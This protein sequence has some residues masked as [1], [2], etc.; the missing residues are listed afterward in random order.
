MTYSIVE[1]AANQF[2]RCSRT[3]LR[4]ESGPCTAHFARLRAP[5]AGKYYRRRFQRP[6][7]AGVQTRSHRRP[8]ATV[9]PLAAG[10]AMR[11][12]GAFRYLIGD[13]V[14]RN[15]LKQDFRSPILR[16]L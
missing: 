11:S 8:A 7:L 9:A 5:P 6:A 4:M 10:A 14:A 1:E 12:C 3:S 16:R 13:V 15:R 2:E